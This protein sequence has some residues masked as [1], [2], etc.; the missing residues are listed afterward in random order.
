MTFKA[1]VTSK[2]DDGFATALTDFS[3]AD[4]GAGDV[5][6]AVEYSTVNFKDGLALAGKRIM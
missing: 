5:T 3:A 1:L 6:V 2:T 4:L